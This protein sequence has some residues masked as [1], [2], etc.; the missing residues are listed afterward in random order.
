ML[1]YKQWI[2]SVE[3]L[4]DQIE[5]FFIKSQYLDQE[6]VSI[7]DLIPTAET[8]YVHEQ[9]ERFCHELE[10]AFYQVKRL[11]ADVIISGKI[12]RGENGRYWLGN[13]ELACGRSVEILYKEEIGVDN[14]EYWHAGRIAHNGSKYYFTGNRNLELEGLQGRIKRNL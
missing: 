13:E 1:K 12:R 11:N 9:L 6:Q 8:L 10:E 5:E 2:K 3:S 7:P 4:Q 14:I